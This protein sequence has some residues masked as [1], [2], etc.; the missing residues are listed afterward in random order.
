MLPEDFNLAA[1]IAGTLRQAPGILQEYYDK[2]NQ[3]AAF[4]QQKANSLLESY[5]ERKDRQDRLA[6]DRQKYQ[7]DLDKFNAPEPMTLEKAIGAYFQTLSPQGQK[8]F[9]TNKYSTVDNP[10][11]QR[12][13]PALDPV[14]MR[15]TYQLGLT[16][17]EKSRTIM[18]N[19]FQYVPTFADSSR[20]AG[21]T[22][23][24]Y[25]VPIDQQDTYLARLLGRTAKNVQPNAGLSVKDRV[26]AFGGA[27][28][29]PPPNDGSLTPK[30]YEEYVALLMRGR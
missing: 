28:F 11:R 19:G 14:A 6:L 16:D 30:E 10:Q 5:L 23:E 27:S 1:A 29:K 25:G 4:D 26:Q 12:T 2:R 8:D 21:Q 15:K 22:V 7:L 20:I 3:Q 9:V 13:T 17:L 24:D 18:Q